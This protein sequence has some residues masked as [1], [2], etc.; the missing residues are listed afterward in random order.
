M[1][2]SVPRT[3]IE[4]IDKSQAPV[5]LTTKRTYPVYILGFAAD[6]GKEDI[7][8]AD[9]DT[10]ALQYLPSKV[11]S[12]VK[13]GQP[14]LTAAQVVA[15][16]GRVI[17]KRVVAKDSYLANKLISA[18]ITVA[19]KQKEDGRGNLIY[20]DAVTGNETVIATGNTPLMVDTVNITYIAES[21]KN[22]KSID[23]VVLI[24]ET[25]IK[26]DAATKEYT[27][28][29]FVITDNGRGVSKKKFRISP[30]Y[31]KSKRLS[32]MKYVLEVMESD[33]AIEKLDFTGNPD[34]LET[35][36]NRSI[37]NVVS[38][39]SDQIKCELIETSYLSFVS[40]V[41]KLSGNTDLVNED[42]F[43]AKDRK[44]VSLPN[45][46][47][48]YT[49][50]DSNNLSYSF[51]ISLDNGDN[52]AFGDFPLNTTAYEQELLEF[53]NGTFSADIYD[54]DNYKIDVY[55]DCNYPAPV[56]RA[57]ESLATFREDG[58][59]FR[60]LGLGLNTMDDILAADEDSLKNR[61]CA[62]YHL[63][64]NVLD[65]YTKK[66]IKVTMLYELAILLVDHFLDGR[67]RPVAG[68]LYNLVLTRAIKGT[69]SFL[70][71][72]TPNVDQKEMLCDNRINYAS[73]YENKLVVETELTAQDENTQLLYIN[74]VLLVQQIVK[75]VRTKCPE[76]RYSFIEG[77]DLTVYNKDI[78]TILDEYSA[79][80]SQ[81]ELVY[82][83]D[84]TMKENKIYY[85][86]ILCVFKDFVQQ[87]YF[88]L[89]ALNTITEAQ[90]GGHLS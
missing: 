14:L 23:D 6:K 47:I 10:F 59:Y 84:D 45:V 86:A 8:V 31:K 56:K 18:K 30:D 54:L 32:Y 81:L 74:N 72:V 11:A 61:Y 80:F 76:I 41:E 66:P 50:T 2:A 28:P 87:E 52:G 53:F 88:K 69:E 60:D 19:T 7:F 57:I 39:F 55:A 27:Y 40:T 1:Y 51:G 67:G 37:Q 63:S 15:A 78:R 17:C 24:A 64:Y 46:V 90:K 70:P 4:V 16:G 65:P 9:N 21:F 33:T 75:A 5:V 29:L 83:E 43:F 62:S 13:Y 36:V 25:K 26:E 77:K 85:A 20:T 22:M 71:K 42:L 3:K 82:L 38:N 79:S 73:Y 44:S 34:I 58:F 35:N 48:D 68:Q 89:Y 12:F 49:S